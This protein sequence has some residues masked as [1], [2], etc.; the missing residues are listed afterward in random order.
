MLKSGGM[1]SVLYLENWGE[2]SGRKSLN[3]RNFDVVNA[4]KKN[5]ELRKDEDDVQAGDTIVLCKWTGKCYTGRELSRKVKYVL[6]HVPEY[7]LQEG[8]CIIGW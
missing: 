8:W 1:H 6:R 7:G 3:W 4:R 5:F 2:N